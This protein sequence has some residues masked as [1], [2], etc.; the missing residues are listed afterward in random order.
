VTVYYDPTKPETAVVEPGVY[1]PFLMPLVFG[2]IFFLGG[3]WGLW[4]SAS[5]FWNTENVRPGNGASR[6]QIVSTVAVSAL[7]YITCSLTLLD[8]AVQET[9]IKAFGARPFGVP[10]LILVVALQTLL[11]VPMPYVFWHWMKVT[12]QALQ[13]GESIGVGYLLKVGRLHPDL[14]RSRSVC[15]GGLL[16]FLAITGAWIVYASNRGI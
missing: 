1:S 8:S 16:Y 13:D 5:Q 12:F 9:L 14:R 10:N 7:V 6:R 15:L 3:L 2:A 4:K 11:F